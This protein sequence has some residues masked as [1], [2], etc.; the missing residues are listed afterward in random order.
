MFLLFCCFVFSLLF[1][2]EFI[3]LC[4]CF[5]L[6][7]AVPL[8]PFF[9]QFLFFLCA[10]TSLLVLCDTMK[11]TTTLCF[12]CHRTDIGTILRVKKITYTGRGVSWTSKP[13]DY[14]IQMIDKRFLSQFF[15]EGQM[16]IQVSQD[17][18]EAESAGALIKRQAP[19]AKRV[20]E[21]DEE[22]V[23]DQQTKPAVIGTTHAEQERH[24]VLKPPAKVIKDPYEFASVCGW[25]LAQFQRRVSKRFC[26]QVRAKFS[27][28]EDMSSLQSTVNA[29]EKKKRQ[30]K[31]RVTSLLRKQL[32][33]QAQRCTAYEGT[34][35]SVPVALAT[36]IEHEK[37]I[38]LRAQVDARVAQQEQS[39]A[40]LDS[41]KATLESTR[42][43]H[44]CLARV[45]DATQLSTGAL[46]TPSAPTQA[47]ERYI[48]ALKQA[49]QEITTPSVPTKQANWIHRYWSNTS[50]QQ[51]SPKRP[52][53]VSMLRPHE[54]WLAHQ[55][56]KLK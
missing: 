41:V 4:L 52:K 51:E 6:V 42:Q 5:V 19:I 43:L 55:G 15:E 47:V 26:D 10:G 22:V 24:F 53:I 48:D 32:K 35:A 34:M 30:L 33:K 39:Q 2:F 7:L 31:A 20:L 17:E 18:E 49:Q 14:Y 1:C 50:T 38:R 11:L 56:L 36:A 40:A 45:I 9:P 37:W 29:L 27:E 3:V 54:D 21:E 12:C 25:K 13:F 46:P 28:M 44:S 8:F 16:P 23:V